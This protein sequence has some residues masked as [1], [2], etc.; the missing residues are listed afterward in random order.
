MQF[1]P[2]QKC[3]V[4][5]HACELVSDVPVFAIRDPGVIGLLF[6]GSVIYLLYAR[7]RRVEWL[8]R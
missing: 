8:M 3:T 5:L 1:V 6:A 2:S 7:N 4:L